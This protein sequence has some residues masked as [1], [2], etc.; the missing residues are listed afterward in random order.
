MHKTRLSQPWMEILAECALGMLCCWVKTLHGSYGWKSL[1][2]STI[3]HITW[4]KDPSRYHLTVVISHT[5][6][7][8]QR[9]P[10]QT[11][12]I[13]FLMTDGKSGV[14][15][16]A[17]LSL[18]YIKGS[19]NN[20]WHLLPSQHTQPRN[21]SERHTREECKRREGSWD[22]LEQPSWRG[23]QAIWTGTSDKG[24]EWQD[25]GSWL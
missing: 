4:K 19:G 8:Y 12:N 9:R 25:K 11:N 15:P 18:S 14:E 7:L 10:L 23:L 16:R 24:M 6:A 20:W 17:E 21:I 2:T 22:T 13:T 3:Q 5:E 1:S